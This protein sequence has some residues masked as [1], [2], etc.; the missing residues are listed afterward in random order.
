LSRHPPCG[1]QSRRNY[2]RLS[3]LVILYIHPLKGIF[4]PGHQDSLLYTAFSRTHPYS[5]SSSIHYR[6]HT[7]RFP[8]HLLSLPIQVSRQVQG[9]AWPRMLFLPLSPLALSPCSRKQTCAMTSVGS[10]QHFTGRTL[11]RHI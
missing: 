3:A 1:F 7:S 10:E 2:L 11:A 6:V 4:Q 9:R 8:P 5:I